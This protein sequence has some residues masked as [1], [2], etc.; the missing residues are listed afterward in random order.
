MQELGCYRQVRIRVQS[1]KTC[2][3][4]H[5]LEDFR[6]A[7][8]SC[9]FVQSDESALWKQQQQVEAEHS[10]K[11][12]AAGNLRQAVATVTEPSAAP[13]RSQTINPHIAATTKRSPS[14]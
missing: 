13:D 9:E 12:F 5:G 4:A 3:F 14:N 8:Y 2:S 10:A 1:G 7:K 6:V 11:K